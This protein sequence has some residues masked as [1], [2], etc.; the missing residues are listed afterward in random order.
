MLLV[1]DCARLGCRHRTRRSG[2][3]MAARPAIADQMVSRSASMANVTIATTKVSTSSTTSAVTWLWSCVRLLRRPATHGLQDERRKAVAIERQ[4]FVAFRRS[5][6]RHLP[7]RASKWKS[8]S[9][10]RSKPEGPSYVVEKVVDAATLSFQHGYQP[11]L[12]N[13][14]TATISRQT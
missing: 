14:T 4:T 9:S 5:L 11:G 2:T 1:Q 7:A 12:L 8:G 6:H 13:W 3:T 10:E